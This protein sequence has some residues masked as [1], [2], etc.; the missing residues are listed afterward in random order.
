M[1]DDPVKLINLTLMKSKYIK[2][3]PE[4]YRVK[5]QICVRGSASGPKTAAA[6][7]ELVRPQAQVIISKFGGAR[8]LARTL[9]ECSEDP[10]D[11][12]DASTIYRWMYPRSKGGTGGQIPADALRTLMKIARL[13][14][15]MLTTE[16]IYP[17]LVKESE[18]EP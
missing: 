8:E 2:P 3:M 16:E 17:H 7:R 9:K 1:T 5:N 14:G 15:V 12:Y 4:T 13:S 18:V 6:R 10:A 11:H